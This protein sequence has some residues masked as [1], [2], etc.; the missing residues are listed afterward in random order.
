MRS[1][2]TIAAIVLSVIV[3][4]SMVGPAIAIAQEDDLELTVDTEGN[5]EVVVTVTANE[6]AVEN[7]TVNVTD[8]ENVTYADAGEY[9]TD[10]NGT[11]SL[12]TPDQ[13][14]AVTITATEGDRIT[15]TSL[16]LEPADTG[17]SVDVDQA[18]D[19]TA[20]ITV[21]DNGSAVENTTVDVTVDDENVT[22]DGA[23]EHTTDENGTVWLPAPEETVNVS[24]VVI[25]PD[26]T[27]STTAQLDPPEGLSVDV[28]QADDGTATVSVTDNSSSVE[29]ATVNVTVDDENATYDGSGEYDTDENGTVGL[30]A[31]EGTVNLTVTAEH[32]NRTASTTALLV[33]PE[34]E[35]DEE[36]ADKPFGQLVSSFVHDLLG[37]E[38]RQ[39]GIGSDVSAFVTANN[40]GVG[41]NETGTP[42]HA[43]GPNGSDEGDDRVPPGQS[44]NNSNAKN[45]SEN[46]NGQSAQASGSDSSG[47]SSNTGGQPD[48]PESN[49]NGNNENGGGPPD[50]AGGPDESED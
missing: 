6:T 8:D 30:P 21:L 34:E 33:A 40:P 44:D 9:N 11:V 38:S 20:T 5:D 14:V 32:D 17:F 3:V 10:E 29:N 13:T 27:A 7:A 31:P 19:G 2:Q 42:D 23:G 28:D 39:G 22:Y 16:V 45:S 18:D 37:N 43:G 50:H 48:K 26:Q 46:V 24:I 4:F 1:N 47:S 36:E 25:A 41:S 49:G 35:D 12:S 15:E